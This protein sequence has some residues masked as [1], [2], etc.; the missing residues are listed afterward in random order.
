MSFINSFKRAFGFPGEY[1]RDDEELESELNDD[2]LE[3][4]PDPTLEECPAADILM[5]TPAMEPIPV[6]DPKAVRKLADGL[7][8]SVLAY[9]NSHQPELVQRC[10]DIDAQRSLIIENMEKDIV[11]RMTA[12]A[13]AACRRGEHKWAEKQQQL[14]AELMKLK[15]EY[16][17]V[18]QQ[19]E[20]S[21]SIQ[22]SATRQK[23]AFTDRIRDLENQVTQLV[24][25][26]EQLQLENKS[27]ASRLRATS[28]DSPGKE[29]SPDE[30]EKLRNENE[31]L[32][33]EL[34]ELRSKAEQTAQELEQMKDNKPDGESSTLSVEVLSEELR[35]ME[36]SLTPLRELK[37]AA[38][39]KVIRLT[40]E[41]KQADATIASLQ[42]RLVDSA[43]AT[44]LAN[45]ETEQ[46]RSTIENNLYLHSEAESELREQIKALNKE[47]A[48]L[49]ADSVSAIAETRG[50]E[51]ET[52]MPVMPPAAIPKKRKKKRKPKTGIGITLAGME[53]VGD[54]LEQPVR[55]S[56]IDELMDSTDWFVA[57]E[58]VP[59]K[60]D[61][62]IEEI[63]GYKEPPKKNETPDDD[64]QLT[65]W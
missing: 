61:P 56:A 24:A 51:K 23:R 4:D 55:I 12:M 8:D 15:S 29:I 13:D 19:Q 59:L 45:R 18:R 42:R 32:R 49:S 1:D 25:D 43:Q 17:A 54:P 62:E 41:I 40:Q 60:K 37:D 26:R 46:L 16:N 5:D 3:D 14:G 9:F 48:R 22:L 34:A 30:T 21:Q 28:P 44:E 6:T 11:D 63:F 36:E 38:E 57:P 39:A 10:L 35:V 53:D 27:M 65:L 64:R 7:F 20:D 50:P 33:N 47:I 58:P 52:E 31:S 2:E